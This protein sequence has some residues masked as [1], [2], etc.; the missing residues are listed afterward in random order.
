[1]GPAQKLAPQWSR[2][3][4]SSLQESLWLAAAVAAV[5]LFDEV[6]EASSCIHEA[7]AGNW[8]GGLLV[9]IG[10]VLVL[11]EA[12]VDEVLGSSKALISP[13]LEGRVDQI[14]VY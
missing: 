8:L 2:R 11:S 3:R 7:L 14:V 9:G 6:G 12:R 5:D 13:G 4:N 10:G 1:M